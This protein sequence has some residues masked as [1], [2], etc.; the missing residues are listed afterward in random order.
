M[1]TDILE[2]VLTNFP[3]S[4]IGGKTVTKKEMITVKFKCISHCVSATINLQ[5][6]MTHMKIK[7]LSE[8]NVFI[9]QN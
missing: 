2:R 1:K 4:Y 7:L 9:Y 8:K 3:V 6:I 5:T